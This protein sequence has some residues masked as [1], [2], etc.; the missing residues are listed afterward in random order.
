MEASLRLTDKISL[1]S[2][3]GEINKGNYI[4]IYWNRSNQEHF[5]TIDGVKTI[6]KPHQITT[7]TFL[8]SVTINDT[9]ELMVF[10]FNREFYC[11]AD[12]D[13][14]VSCNGIL[15]FG[16][17]EPPVLT[18]IDSEQTSME[19]LFQIF[20]DEFQTKDNIQ[21]EMLQMLLKRLI[22][23][24][25]RLA[26][27]Q[28]I[29]AVLK[30]DQIDIV[31]R[32]NVLVDLNF[33]SLKQVAD[34]ADLLHKSP[35]TLSNLFK[36]YNQKTPLGIIHERI[37]L[38]GKRLLTK[39][40]MSSKEIAFEIGFNDVSAFNKIFKR[41]TDQSPIDYRKSQTQSNKE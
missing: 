5:I 37:V 9:A 41:I 8:Q 21:G 30:Q 16:T 29:P 34:Y 17:Q 7:S 23:K 22:I 40:G 26:R 39:T 36:Q 6:L 15:F 14:E 35:K 20:I 25:T 3:N 27:Q 11:I 2:Q 10:S 1:I 13:E 33:K 18:I 19:T 24:C 12:H 32:Y 28:L 31:R 38:E 4:H